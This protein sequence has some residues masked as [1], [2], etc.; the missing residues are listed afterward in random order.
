MITFINISDVLINQL[1][2]DQGLTKSPKQRGFNDAGSKS[3][4]KRQKR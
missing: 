3:H 2:K 4:L 1:L